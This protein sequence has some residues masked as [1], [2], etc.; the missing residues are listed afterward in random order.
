[1]IKTL[2]TSTKT[3]I[4]V[5]AASVAQNTLT[6]ILMVTVRIVLTAQMQ[7]RTS[8]ITRLATATVIKVCSS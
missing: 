7:D 8:K 6:A 4:P 5:S 3:K 1:M 2:T